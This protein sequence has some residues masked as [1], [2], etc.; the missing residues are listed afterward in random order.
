MP[1]Y[2]GQSF[3]LYKNI[4]RVTRLGTTDVYIIFITDLVD[5]NVKASRAI[6][7]ADVSWSMLQEFMTEDLQYNIDAHDI[8]YDNNIRV[9]HPPI[10]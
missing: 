6:V 10:P 2:T 7:T 4:I 9:T 8:F 5:K 3:K 1:L